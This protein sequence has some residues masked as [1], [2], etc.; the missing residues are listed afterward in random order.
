MSLH[1]DQNK[2]PILDGTNFNQWK[3]RMGCLLI[4]KD[5]EN[6][7]GFDYNTFLPL[8]EQPTLVGEDIHKDRKAKAI[9]N[10]GI[11][12]SV[13]TLTQTSASSHELWKQLHATYNRSS[14]AAVA[15]AL[16]TFIHTNKGDCQ[17]ITDYIASAQQNA[18]ALKNTGVP[19]DDKVIIALILSNLPQEYDDVITA[20]YT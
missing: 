15:A 11:S 9:I 18:T 20:L 4:S 8:P 2:L 1:D 16:K 13:A 19:L 14:M 17:S 3:R 5:F 12:D 6:V 7:V 10:L